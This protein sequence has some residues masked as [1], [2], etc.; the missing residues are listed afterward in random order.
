M[1]LINTVNGLVPS[2]LPSRANVRQRAA[3]L[4]DLQPQLQTQ[5]PETDLDPTSRSDQA[6]QSSLASPQRSTNPELS[7]AALHGL[8]GLAVRTIAS[9]PV[10][11]VGVHPIWSLS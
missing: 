2:A 8:A 1:M 4:L 9:I 5:P 6:P 11:T 10:H 3:E 7:E